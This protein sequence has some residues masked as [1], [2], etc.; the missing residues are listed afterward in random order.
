M[1][2]EKP[3]L[4]LAPFP[5]SFRELCESSQS[6]PG[7]AAKRNGK[8]C[9]WRTD[10]MELSFDVTDSIEDACTRLSEHYYHLVLVDCRHLPRHEEEAEEQEKTLFAFLDCL[11]SEPDRERRYPFQRVL[12][13]VGDENEERVDRLIFAMGRRH[14][15][16]CIRDLSLSSRLAGTRRKEARR[17]FLRQILDL[18]HRTLMVRR[19]GKKALCLAGGGITGIY[20]ELGVL[21]CL[22]D[23]MDFDLRDFDLFCG[24]SAGAV[25]AGSL[26]NGYSVDE[27][28]RYVGRLDPEEPYKVQ[29]GWRQLNLGEIPRRLLLAQ[30]DL[31]QYLWRLVK[32]QD[33]LS[34]TG[35]SGAYERL[36]GPIFDNRGFERMLRKLFTREGRSNDFREL[37]ARL[38]IGATDQDRRNHVLFGSEGWD[39]VPISQAIQASAAVHPFFPSVE[40]DG[41]FYTDGVVTRTSNLGAAI[42]NGA[43]L[44]FIADPFLPLI[45]EQP[46]HN[47]RHGNMWVLQQDFKTVAFTRFKQ[48]SDEILRRNPQVGAYTFVPSNRMRRLMSTNP[49]VASNFHSIV[50]EAYRST[51][52]RLHTMEYKLRGELESHGIALDLGY[53]DEKVEILRTARRPDVR[54]LLAEEAQEE[55]TLRV[56]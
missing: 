37:R 2:Q 11:E 25:V 1:P 14:V 41:R 3:A 35:I 12:V 43:D 53:V 52:R 27:M 20:Y 38:L 28:L 40:I 29:L 48:L 50:C 18:A 6:H 7:L 46:G 30:Q 49:F 13:L 15:G 19:R 36:L 42:R 4:F 55:T 8:G 16:A 54:H 56:G 26:A 9:R 5:D 39:H 10:G 24:I 45:S 22:N 32:R 51:Y 34:I 33:E 31:A 17:D 23:A 21:K 44:V 47:A